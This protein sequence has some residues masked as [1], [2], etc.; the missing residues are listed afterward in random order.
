MEKRW[1][2]DRVGKEDVETGRIGKGWGLSW[3]ELA[4]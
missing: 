1:I 2:K 3:E 4:E